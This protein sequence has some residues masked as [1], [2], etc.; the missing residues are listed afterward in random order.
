MYLFSSNSFVFLPIIIHLKFVIFSNSLATF[1][2]RSKP[3]FL[4]IYLPIVKRVKVSFFFL[5]KDFIFSTGEQFGIIMILS[6][7]IP[8]SK[9][10][11]EISDEIA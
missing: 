2:T 4:T 9:S 7:L 10:S 11:F 5:L 3:F 6:F 1:S 8:I